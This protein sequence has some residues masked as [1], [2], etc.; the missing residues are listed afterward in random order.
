[1][2]NPVDARSDLY[3]LGCILYEMLTGSKIYDSAN[4]AEV[5]SMHV[6]APVPQL[7]A[8]LV[9]YQPILERLLAKAPDDRFQSAAELLASL[10]S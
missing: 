8:L 4:S 6:S 2:G 1:M 9:D 5:I 10:H 7:A 3:S